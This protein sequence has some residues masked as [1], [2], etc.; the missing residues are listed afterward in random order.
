MKFN[1]KKAQDFWDAISKKSTKDPTR[2]GDKLRLSYDTEF[3]LD[4]I[5]ILEKNHILDLGA[6]TG[7]LSI[8]LNKN[9]NNAEFSLVEKNETFSNSIPK[10]S[11]FII[12]NND[13]IDYNFNNFFDTALLFG[14]VNSIS[15][16]S[17]I[18][19]YKKIHQNL[20]GGVFIIKHQCGTNADVIFDD[21]SDAIGANYTARY[22]FINNQINL[23]RT[24]F[25]VEQYDIYPPELNL[26]S[27]THFYAFVCN[28]K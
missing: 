12:S 3:V 9:L 5:K 2:H 22:P 19:L 4:K 24:F 21:Y 10:L 7:Q 26:H 16:E 20:K 28:S 23:L 1:E 14:V 18:E 15:V 13:L 25:Q 27:N 6:G 11:N 17:E 8:E